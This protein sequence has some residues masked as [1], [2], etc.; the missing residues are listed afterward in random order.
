MIKTQVVSF[1]LL[2]F[3][4]SILASG[5]L[6]P[7]QRRPI[8]SNYESV[9]KLDM[10]N[11]ST[12]T[13]FILSKNV[14][15]TASHCILDS[16]NEKVT[17]TVVFTDKTR[18]PFKIL[19][20][21]GMYA[22]QDWALIAA[23]TGDRRPLRFNIDTPTIGMFTVS[24]GHP[25]GNVQQETSFGMLMSIGQTLRISGV[26]F[27]GESGSPILFR[28]SE[29]V[30][31]ILSATYRVAPVTIAT[32]IAPLARKFFELGFTQ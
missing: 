28:D 16:G 2:F 17:G 11:M 22:S 26:N 29:E 21:G 27:P 15:G 8:K 1:A 25:H 3:V 4:C 6:E 23:E 5:M 14:L 24:I 19:A 10:D 18:K 31:G 32:P 7:Y 30:I 20:Y 13:G 12:C 9:V